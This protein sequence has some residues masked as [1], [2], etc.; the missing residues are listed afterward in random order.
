MKL[1]IIISFVSAAAS[2]AIVFFYHFFNLLS[3]Q[4]PADGSPVPSDVTAFPPSSA[5]MAALPIAIIVFVLVFSGVFL[6]KKY[7]FL[8]LCAFIVIVLIC[9]LGYSI[10]PSMLSSNLP[11]KESGARNNAPA[12]I[13][14]V[15][16]AR[17]SAEQFLADKNAANKDKAQNIALSSKAPEEYS[18]GWIFFA[19]SEKYIETGAREDIVPGIGPLV[20]DRRGYVQFLASSVPPKQAIEEYERKFNAGL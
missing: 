12:V 2:F 14:S 16:D 3:K 8:F 18:F 13:V 19:G 5:W 15:E 4:P 20:V 9:A 10:V 7:N 6:L 11:S 1:P 17:I